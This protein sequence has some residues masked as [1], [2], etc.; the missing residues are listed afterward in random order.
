MHLEL[1]LVLESTW[2]V[3]VSVFGR[4]SGSIFQ[5]PLGRE[6]TLQLVTQTIQVY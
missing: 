5:L 2:L 3:N 4:V 6:S 1:G